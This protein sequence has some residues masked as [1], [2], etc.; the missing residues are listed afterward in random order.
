VTS[1]VG[2]LERWRQHRLERNRS[3]LVQLLRRT[4][5]GTH[6][7]DR[8]RDRREALHYRAAAVRTPLLELAAV[9]EHAH[10]PDPATVAE[11]RELLSNGRDSPLY[12]AKI[13]AAELDKALQRIRAE[14]TRPA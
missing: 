8:V 4:A 6:D 10:D 9:L 7:T 2:P 11:L 14:L 5:D 1:R 12:N 13:P 3:A